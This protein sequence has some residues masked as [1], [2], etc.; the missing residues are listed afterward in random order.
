MKTP[1][2]SL[3]PAVLLL[4]LPLVGFGQT[5]W[6][7][8][9]AGSN[10]SVDSNWSTNASPAGTDVIF[11]ATGTTANA[12][13][14]GNIVE[15]NFSI[16]ALTYNNTSTSTW[17]VTQI[18]SL[19]TLTVG[20]AF[21]V[22]TT[23]AGAGL[24]T[25]AAFTGTGTLAVNAPSLSFT[26]ASSAA[27]GTASRATLDMSDLSTFTA[28][29]S[30]FN[31]GTGN[32][33]FGTLYL[34]DNSTITAGSI[35]S[36]GS[37][38]TYSGS[39]QSNKIYLGTTTVLNADTLSLAGV[40]TFGIVKFRG[41][42]DLA[43]NSTALVNPSLKIRAADGTSAAAMNVGVWNSGSSNATGTSSVDLT[44][45]TVDAKVTT[46]KVGSTNQTNANTLTANLTI[47]GGTFDATTVVVGETTGTGAGTVNGNLNVSGGT[48][49]AG[50]MTLANTTNATAA[51]GN[52]TLSGTTTK[53]NVT[54][55]LVMGNRTAA[56][57]TP[58]V[59]VSGGTLTVGGNLA[60]GTGTASSI[61][62]AVNLSGGTLDMTHGTVTVDTFAF[63]GGTLKNVA[64][65]TGSLNVQNTA[66]LGFDLDG[67]SPT[68]TLT[69][70][71]LG[72][73]SNLGLSLLN[74]ITP[75]ASYT[76]VSGTISGTF[77]TVNGAAFDVGNTF[78]LSNNLGT[79][80]GTL[81]YNASDITL[82]LSAIPEPSTY[83]ALTGVIALGMVAWRRKRVVSA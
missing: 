69:G 46:L 75:S 67:T 10:W 76:L 56:T 34:A 24:T 32:T 83:A 31:V 13:T 48:F 80:I 26:V 9:T 60:E 40:R 45:G 41:V 81:T 14:I 37:G 59:N 62:S 50:T 2:Y 44:G 77:L 72:G 27:T 36:G 5:T 21:R 35:T 58:T 79:Y 29:V 6:N 68:L 8:A 11:G 61:V 71:T 54:G 55:N 78:T 38:S 4:G 30:T 73:S 74:D 53:V 19:Q 23:Q 82:A 15:Q 7:T 3:I 25:L 64:T 57:V 52:L 12:A 65:F 70:L 33:G 17:Q 1:R 20:G 16:N 43:A 49:T 47:D 39:T 22:G 51:K 28:N 66:T 42:L 63:T 18:A